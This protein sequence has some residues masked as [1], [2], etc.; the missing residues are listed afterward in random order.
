V[1][2]SADNNYKD[3]IVDVLLEHTGTK[4]GIRMITE[5]N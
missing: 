4:D 2:A 5:N 3:G 1:E